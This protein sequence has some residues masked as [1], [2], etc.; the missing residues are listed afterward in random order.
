V[1][2]KESYIPN[3]Q[4]EV[5][6]NGAADRATDTQAGLTPD[7]AKQLPKRPG[8]AVGTL[9]LSVPPLLRK[10]AVT[11]TPAEAKLEPGGETTV[12]VEVKDAA[13]TAVGGGELAVVVVDESILALSN[14]KMTD[15]LEVFYTQR[16]AD[17]S[18]YHSRQ[19][20]LLANATDLVGRVQGGVQG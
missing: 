11:A 9:N 15:P 1:P 20:V 16:G 13:G 7:K 17:T 14:Y 12:A 19:Q 6:L 5:D 4:V 3:V 8:F 10:L 2:I 18:D